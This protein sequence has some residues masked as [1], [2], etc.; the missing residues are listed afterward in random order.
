MSASSRG[1]WVCAS[2]A[3]VACAA[4][5]LVERMRDPA[6]ETDATDSREPAE[7]VASALPGARRA[8]RP[9]SLPFYEG[10]EGASAN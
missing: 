6:L 5:D 1:M 9:A 2:M 7:P 10:F 8:S 3:V 4:R